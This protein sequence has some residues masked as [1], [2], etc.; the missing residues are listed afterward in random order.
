MRSRE[1]LCALQ[2]FNGHD[3]R[4]RGEVCGVGGEG[5]TAPGVVG[6]TRLLVGND[7]AV[8]G[9]RP[10]R[11]PSKRKTTAL[12]R[13]PLHTSDAP[14]AATTAGVYQQATSTPPIPHASTTSSSLL[15]WTN[16]GE[17][18]RF[19]QT[20]RTEYQE[21]AL[22]PVGFRVFGIHTFGSSHRLHNHRD[23]WIGQV[24][25]RK[26]WWFVPPNEYSLV[27]KG[28]S[29]RPNACAFMEGWQ[30]YEG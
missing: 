25:G 19:L 4:L 6:E 29:E 2:V 28:A 18:A 23:A 7:P 26:A 17:N 24:A 8:P 27:E 12:P 21:P 13:M 9:P 20:L 1:F 3:E 30:G 16:D 14:P 5:S 15:F 22:L 11:V 10:F